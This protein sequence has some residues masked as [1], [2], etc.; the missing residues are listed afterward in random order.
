MKEQEGGREEVLVGCIQID[1]HTSG[2]P[3]AKSAVGLLL[4]LLLGLL[5]LLRLLRL[6]LPDL[7]I[8]VKCCCSACT[9]CCCCCTRPEEAG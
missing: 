6:L 7:G 1:D 8:T 5:R 4:L 9:S 2:A 3:R